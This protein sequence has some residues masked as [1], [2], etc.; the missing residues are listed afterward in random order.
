MKNGAGIYEFYLYRS[1]RRLPSIIGADDRASSNNVRMG[2]LVGSL[3]K[4]D[5][6]LC[7]AFVVSPHCVI[8]ARHCYAN[9]I[10]G[11]FTFESALGGEVLVW[12]DTDYPELDLVEL[13]V[14]RINPGRIEIVSPSLSFAADL[15]PRDRVCIALAGDDAPWIWSYFTAAFPDGRQVLDY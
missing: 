8:T 12:G 11:S 2:Q 3:L 7:T 4:D 14:R 15:I 9:I 10:E 13:P 1:R 5:E 6:M